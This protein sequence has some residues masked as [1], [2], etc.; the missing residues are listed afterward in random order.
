MNFEKDKTQ[1]EIRDSEDALNS[2]KLKESNFKLFLQLAFFRRED[3]PRVGTAGLIV[4][5]AMLAW[6]GM[7]YLYVGPLVDIDAVSAREVKYRVAV[8]TAS[9]A[10]FENLPGVGQ[11]LARSIIEYRDQLGGFKK[12]E[13]MLDVPRIGESKFRQMR[14]YLV[15]HTKN[16]TPADESPPAE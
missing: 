4:F 2:S 11:V 1:S 5:A 10:E 13:Q 3:L 12:L 6:V 15:L 8:N 7:K 14:P 9:A 16:E